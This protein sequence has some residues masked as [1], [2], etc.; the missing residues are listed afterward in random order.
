MCALVLL[1]VDQLNNG[2]LYP[3]DNEYNIL[4]RACYTRAS[5]LEESL[6]LKQC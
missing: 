2:R 4:R 1:K 5:L 6:D 3:E